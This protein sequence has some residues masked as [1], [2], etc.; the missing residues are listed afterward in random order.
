MLNAQA[1]MRRAWC[2]CGAA[3]STI[4]GHQWDLS[5]GYRRYPISKMSLVHGRTHR[6]KEQLICNIRFICY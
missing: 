1:H 5:R 2:N 6:L 3:V 4:I